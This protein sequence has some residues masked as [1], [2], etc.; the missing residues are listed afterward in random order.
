M[1]FLLIY[2][3]MM[4]TMTYITAD[5][6]KDRLIEKTQELNKNFINIMTQTVP[7]WD[8]ENEEFKSITPNTNARIYQEMCIYLHS[9][10]YENIYLRAEIYNGN[11]EL[12]AKTGNVL[13]LNDLYDTRIATHYLLLDDYMSAD[14]INDLFAP[15]DFWNSLN[16]EV[17]GLDGKHGIIPQKIE[18]F[19]DFGHTEL[20]AT[21]TIGELSENSDVFGTWDNCD[22]NFERKGQNG[23]ITK[24]DLK[25]Y[26]N[27]TKTVEPHLKAYQRDGSL[28]ENDPIKENIFVVKYGSLGMKYGWGEPESRYLSFGAEFYPLEIALPQL[29]P[30]YILSLLFLAILMFILTVKLNNIFNKQAALEKSRRDLTNAVAHELKTPLGVIR[31]YSE[32]LKEKINEDKRDHYLDVVIKETEYMDQMILEMLTLSKLE[33]AQPKLNL[34]KITLNEL[35]NNAI[36]RFDKMIT[37]KQIAVSVSISNESINCDPDMIEK[38]ISIFISNAVRCTP[39]NGTIHICIKSK[40]DKTLF[41]I[42]NSGNLIPEDKINL[43]WDAYYKIDAARTRTE[44]TGLGLSIAK[45]ILNL[46]GFKYGVKN[47]KNGVK[48]WFSNENNTFDL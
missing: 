48:F 10:A 6:I 15:T 12:I 42:E 11:N 34:R 9:A 19:D 43:I 45:S 13:I 14:E 2:L 47:T 46:H 25:R 18:L 27:C 37:A 36:M 31:S 22:A 4:G 32:G 28:I 21:K 35:I 17:I 41:S 39:E 30:V 23:K 29:I 26:Q 33:T 7:E 1:A 44:G 16:A 8:E 5:R 24:T 40:D 20:L 3:V 38:V